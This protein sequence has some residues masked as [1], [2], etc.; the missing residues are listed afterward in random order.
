[1]K[2]GG[3]KEPMYGMFVDAKSKKT[4]AIC[5][6][7]CINGN[8]P[9]CT[10]LREQSHRFAEWNGNCVMLLVSDSA[11]GRRSAGGREFART[12]AHAGHALVFDNYHLS[13][14]RHL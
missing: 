6:S 5:K 1:M 3:G 2:S 12:T 8:H 13:S 11:D 10:V 9:S 7:F 4:S 14:R